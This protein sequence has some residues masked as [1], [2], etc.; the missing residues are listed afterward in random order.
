MNKELFKEFVQNEIDAKNLILSSNTL[1]DDDKALLESQVEN[2][3]AMINK[4]DGMDADETTNE[5][6]DELKNI[7]NEMSDKIK[8]LNEKI[9]QDK[10]DEEMVEENVNTNYLS[11][12]NSVSDF[13]KAIRNSS[14]RNEFAKNWE[15]KLVENGITIQ[16]G[17][18]AAF[19]PDAVR[20]MIT[21]L[22]DRNAGWL[23]DLKMVGASRYQIRHNVSDQNASTSRAKGWKKGQTK[24]TQELELSA[25]LLTTEWIYKIQ[26]FSYD[27]EFDS[28]EELLNYVLTE[29][30]DSLLFEVKKSILTGDGREANAEG[31]ITKIEAIAKAETDA[32]TTVYSATDGGFL[33]DDMRAM[34]DGI[35]NPNDKPIYVFMSKTDLRT[36]SRVQASESSTPVYLPLEQVAAQI[37]NNVTI[38]T[39][40]LLGETYKALAMIP[41][42]YV[43]IGKGN[44]LNPTLY[45]WHEPRENKDCTRAEFKIGGGISGLKSTAVLKA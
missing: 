32:Y 6:I 4:I 37:G 44:I 31:K 17:S 21:D 29:L 41:S 2:L 43:V 1:T 39:T 33:V 12:E 34:V 11:S 22:W 5:D 9:N 14:N 35:H 40:D 16:E 10:T 38:I 7:V 25:K 18:E 28:D 23:K 45:T 15:G 20:G 13:C 30:V 19:I 27:D 3:T 36:L 26:E 8:A 24:D 42:E